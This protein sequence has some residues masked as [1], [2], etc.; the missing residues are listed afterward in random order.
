MRWFS[1]K[2]KIYKYETALPIINAKFEW[3]SFVWSYYEMIPDKV[4]K[5]V[6]I[7]TSDTYTTIFYE[8]VDRVNA[9]NF[10]DVIDTLMFYANYSSY[11]EQKLPGKT[12]EA[13]I[14]QDKGEK[15]K[16]ALQI[17]IADVENN[18][19]QH[20]K[21]TAGDYLRSL[22]DHDDYL[23]HVKETYEQLKRH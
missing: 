9:N 5:V 22:K 21:C 20:V 11:E 10:K 7:K 4:L 16:K 3:Q 18:P 19:W 14:M 13:E 17:L 1:K 8:I 6:D 23:A 2:K 12:I 15:A